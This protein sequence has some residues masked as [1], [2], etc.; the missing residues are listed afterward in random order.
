MLFSSLIPNED[1]CADGT[2]GWIYA[3]N[4]QTG[5]RTF[6]PALDFNADGRFDSNDTID[7][8][9]VSGFKQNS[10]GGIALSGD[11]MIFGGSGN[12]VGFSPSPELEGRQSWQ[13]I[14]LED[15]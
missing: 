7:G 11:G 2:S 10:P 3:L 14:P 8:M 15:N 4:A 1:P 9:V 5:A 13:V 12:G 6:H